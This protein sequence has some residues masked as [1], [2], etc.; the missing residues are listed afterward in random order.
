MTEYLWL[1]AVAGGP[2]VL[3]LAILYART[4]QRRLSAEEKAEQKQAIREQYGSK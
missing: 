1:L 4:H 2:V 3:A